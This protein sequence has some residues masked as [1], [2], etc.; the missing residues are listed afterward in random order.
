MIGALWNG[1]IGLSTY[2][3]AIAVESNNV[4]NA[5]TIGHKS[6]Q[7]IFED[8]MY[9]NGFGKGVG[10]QTINKNFS[11]GGIKL[12]NV[13]LDVAIEGKGFFIVTERT[14]GNIYYTRAGNFQQ[15]EDGFLETQD[16][17][18]VLGLSPQVRNIIST[19][20]ADT[21][22]TNDFSRNMISTNVYFNE[23]V[24]N[25]NARVSD[26]IASATSDLTT[27]DNSKT[28]SSKILDVDYMKKNYLEKLALFQSNPTTVSIPSI[29]QSSEINF[30]S[31]LSELKENTDYLSVTLNGKEYKE[32]FDTDIATTLNNFSDKLSNTEGFTSKVDT[33]TGILTITGMVPGKAFKISEAKI[34]DNYLNFSNT[35]D[36]VEGSGLAMIESARTAFKNAVENANAKF[37]EITNTLSYADKSVIGNDE[38]NT[39]LNALGLMEG[40]KG[41]ITISD[42]GL[43]F[44]TEGDNKFLI[45]KIQTAHFRNEQGLKAT[46]TNTFEMTDESGMALNADNL[47]KLV[48]TALENPNVTYSNTLSTLLFYQKAFEA[49]SKSISTSDDFIKT[50]ID[51][52]K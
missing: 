48:S 16:K 6:D 32:Y 52:I 5:A 42:D 15:A 46:G 37:L 3:R 49:N 11:Q 13:D 26:Y 31:S 29:S 27:G 41:T 9:K 25:I 22:F 20:S 21:M 33:S 1:V 4:S 10:I 43:V 30:S 23:S 34:N 47:N 2:D 51:M 28:S 38:I 39:R 35:R 12:T 50:A 40:A 7:I 44:L 14:T 8:L 45:S 19:N 18:K 17:M 36:A 24:M